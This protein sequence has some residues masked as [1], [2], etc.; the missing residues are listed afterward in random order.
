MAA[1]ANDSV[2]D[3]RKEVQRLEIEYKLHPKPAASDYS[4]ALFR[5][6]YALFQEHNYTEAKDALIKS[7]LVLAKDGGGH[8]DSTNASWIAVCC[9]RLGQYTEAEKYY[10]KAIE[11]AKANCKLNHEEMSIGLASVMLGLGDVYEHTG[12]LDA[13]GSLYREVAAKVD[14]MEAD[15]GQRI[16]SPE[17][18][19]KLA[20]FLERKG[21][22]REA[23]QWWRRV[24]SMRVNAHAYSIQ[25]DAL[26]HYAAMLRK[27]RRDKEASPLEKRAKDLRATQNELNRKGLQY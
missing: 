11:E 13:A 27:E 24:A 20:Q 22:S 18:F 2:P 25:A 7:D 3:L 16:S 26:A 10:T 14:K 19:D 5:L 23:E 1:R 21:D 9:C 12:R 4:L 17:S 8:G 6:G 15:E